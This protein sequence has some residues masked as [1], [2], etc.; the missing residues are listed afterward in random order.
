MAV[1]GISVGL[2]LIIGL[3]A[4]S[5]G[6]QSSTAP[7]IG[8]SCLIGSWLL[9]RETNQSGYTYA[10]VPV[11]VD[12]LA[13]AQ[14]SLTA[15]GEEKET[16][17]GSAPLVGTLANGLQLSITIRGALI[18]QIHAASGKYQETGSV[19]QMPTTA[20]AG[21]V[22]VA[23]Y[24]SSYSPGRGTYSCGGGRL[25]ITTEGGNQTD[26]WTKG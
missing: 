21:G 18:F 14:L 25:T 1:R 12:G 20:T 17:D 13:G 19:V 4:C 15:G 23:N 22:P 24:R 3:A 6:G 5:L 2:A 10:G 16:F 8:D 11:A 9:A 26:V 7:Q